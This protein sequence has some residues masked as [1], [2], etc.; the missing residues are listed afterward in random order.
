MGTEVCSVYLRDPFSN[1]LVF[2]ATEG[3]NKSQIGLL[4]LAHNEG[5]V[6]L[7]ATRE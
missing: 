6:G 1:R 4:S 5:L 7:V 2:R 3:L